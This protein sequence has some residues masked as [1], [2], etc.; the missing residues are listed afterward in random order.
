MKKAGP[1]GLKWLKIAHILLISLFFGGIMSSLALNYGMSLAVYTD[2]LSTYKHL[3][4]ISDLIVRTGAI[5]TMLLAFI[6]GFFTNW[7]FFRHRWLTVKWV[8]FILQTLIGIFIIDKLMMTNMALLEAEGSA[9]LSNAGFI[10][11]HSIRQYAVILQISI[12]LF[13]MIISV[14]KPWKK[15]KL[16]KKGAVIN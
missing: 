11:N 2:T 10:Q 4:E 14:W 3:V 15:K 13:I 12:T 5:G 6:Y 7:G 9:A 1:A 8:L 16:H